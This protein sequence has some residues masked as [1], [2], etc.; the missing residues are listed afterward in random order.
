LDGLL[1]TLAKTLAATAIMFL[2]G[3]TIMALMKNLPDGR[4]SDILR[5]AVVVP[6][7]A[8]AYVLAAKFLHIEMLSLFT[9]GR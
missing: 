2:V 4:S 9:G 1:V 7:A 3:A 5:L 6:S 8:A